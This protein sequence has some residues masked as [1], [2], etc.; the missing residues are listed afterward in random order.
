MMAVVGGRPNRNDESAYV[1]FI[2]FQ[3]SE[4]A[5]AAGIQRCKGWTDYVTN[6]RND[7]SFIT[8]HKL[9]RSVMHVHLKNFSRNS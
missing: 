9:M 8:F 7:W 1:W 3:F 5:S 2:A 4:R 6:A